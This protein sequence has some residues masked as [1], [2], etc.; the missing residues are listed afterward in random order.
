VEPA[1]GAWHGTFNL[2][3]N[4]MYYPDLSVYEY[5]GRPVPGVRNIGW[6]DVEHEF[7]SGSTSPEVLLRVRWLASERRVGQS[8]GYHVCPF[9]T[10]TQAERS[11]AEIWVPDPMTGGYFAG[12]EL[13]GHYIDAHGYAPPRVFVDAVEQL[14]IGDAVPDLDAAS[15]AF[16]AAA[17]G[18]PPW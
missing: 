2:N 11:S 4:H 18:P 16:M 15:D 17:W 6:L 8:R 10:G 7:C 9:C 13:V 14:G 12:P 1:A 3:Y 5:N